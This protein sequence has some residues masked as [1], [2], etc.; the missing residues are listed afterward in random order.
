MERNRDYSVGCQASIDAWSELNRTGCFAEPAL[1]RYVAAMPPPELMQN[2]SGLTNERD[3]AS[4]GV[5]FYRALSAA[6]RKSLAEY[7]CLLDFGCG[8]GRFLRMLKGHP[9]EIHGCDI[10]PRHIGWVRDHLPYVHARKSGIRPPLPYATD[11]FDAIVS[12]SIFTHLNE[13]AQDQFLAELARIAR[14]DAELFI[15]VHGARALE[16]ALDEPSIHAMIDVPD[17]P[18]ARACEEFSAGRHA[19]ILQQ[20]HLSTTSGNELV[21][22]PFE[23]GITFIPHTYLCTH[24]SQWFEIVDIRPG[25][26]HDFQDIV[27]L[28]PKK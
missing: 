9:H 26:I 21:D 13:T 1:R 7:R 4:H 18:F 20:G 10:D 16:R 28:R 23:Y 2:V 24:W 14:P 3:F 6:A 17:V 5:D 12:I 8:V 15:T 27:C 11:T 22:G 25:G 19:F